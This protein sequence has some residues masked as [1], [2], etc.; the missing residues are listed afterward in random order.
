MR[1]C[2]R[3]SQF[4]LS[5]LWAA[6]C[7]LSLTAAFNSSLRAEPPSSSVV[8]LNGDQWLL[9]TDPKN[10]GREEKWFESPRPEAK[11]TKVPWIIQDAFPGYSGV[12][13]YWREFVAP[14]HPHPDG[15]YLLRFWAVDY[16]ADVWVNG[17]HVGTHEGAEIPFVLDI[18]E[19]VKPA[20]TNRLAVRV[21][22]VNQQRT[23]GLVMG[24]VPHRLKNL[25]VEQGLTTGG[26]FNHG[27]IE[28]S[29]ELLVTAPVRV[30]DLYVISDWQTGEIRVQA[31][32]QNSAA[33]PV[34]ARVQF[35]VAPAAAGETLD[36]TTVE[37]DLPVGETPVTGRLNVS[38]HRLWQLNDPYLYRI[39]ARATG[40]G[41]RAIDE[42]STRC[43]FRDF[44]FQNGYFRLNG[45]RIYLRCSHIG[46]D[47]PI[48]LQ[49]PHDPDVLRRTLLNV[50]VMGFNAVRFF[51]AVPQRFQLDLCDEIGLLA[52]E[53]SYAGWGLGDSPK[54]AERFDR[55]VAGMI[56][57]DRNHPSVVMWGL[58]N[59][60]PDGPVFRHA[61][62]MLPL[63]RSLDATRMVVLNSGRWDRTG[64]E[65]PAGLEVWQGSTTDP[66]VSRNPTERPIRTAGI[67]WL[68]GATVFHPGP[69]G[70]RCV[71]RWTTPADGEY[72][73]LA[74][75]RSAAARATT[76]VHVRR[77]ATRLFDG[78][79]NLHD[80]KTDPE[81]S[82]KLTLK[83]GETLDFL[84]GDGG[85]GY[86]ADSTEISVSITAA[87]GKIYDLSK[88]F[89]AARN[90]NGAWSYGH[91]PGSAEDPAAFVV[92]PKGLTFQRRPAV[93]SISNP[94]S[95]DWEDVLADV[96]PY[97]RSPATAGVIQT[98]R[99]LHGDG[100]PVFMSEYGIGSAVDLVRVTRHYERLASTHSMDAQV[101]RMRLEAFL[102]DWAR[103]G[104]GEC[105]ASPED[106]F[107]QCLAKMAGERLLGLNALRTNP[108]I[109]GHSMSSTVDQGI[110]GEGVFTTFRELKP[111]TVDALF[112]G[113][114]AL[115]LCLFVEP[116]HVYRGDKVRIEA[117]LANEDALPP[118]EYPV[119]LQVVGTAGR[120]VWERS[121]TLKI[122]ERG[123]N[124][125]PPL[126]MPFFGEEVTVDGAAGEYR[127]L[128]AFER[129]A[130]A[131][132]GEQRFHVTDR[133]DMPAVAVE[134]T[135]WGND[136]GLEQ[137]LTAHGIRVRRFTAEQTQREMIVASGPAPAEPRAFAVLAEHMARGSTVLFLTPETLRRGDH[138][139]GWIPLANKGTLQS[140]PHWL[141]VTD[142]WAKAHPFFE[143]LPCGGLLDY[144]FYREIIPDVAWTGQEPAGQCVA[145]AINAA[146][147]YSSGTLLSVHPFGAGR[148]VLNS[149]LIRPKLGADPVAERLLRNLLRHAA[150]EVGQPP[151]PLPADFEQQLKTLGY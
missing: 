90:P 130:A 142:E 53:E 86:G 131:A 105:F 6:V 36:A 149:F 58:L 1:S 2:T 28:G 14:A 110:S 80:Q 116:V 25:T 114:A 136:P 88:D 34:R 91:V 133:A 41:S 55:T 122:P 121:I 127:F 44:R 71:I 30:S 129:G 95:A 56:R 119:R 124:P 125:E 151:A 31:T 27:G 19:A 59:E 62:G 79:V 138:A 22:N 115:R 38:G 87:D 26:E 21:L 93:G 63:I 72:Q 75:F 50:K 17:R 132:G 81:Y 82:A 83:R 111:G 135:L 76:D 37:Q 137:W 102:R 98:L 35:L 51:C 103:L 146:W 7:I 45:K 16:L 29:V 109:V 118:G 8:S 141:Y 77:G 9:A 112:D 134:V 66:N 144:T 52:Y 65:Q 23:D 139:A 11:P 100:Q 46:N 97:Q 106:Y 94:G 85:N 48:G 70:E 113:W 84:V 147:G 92:Y 99:T 60:T 20:D 39:T 57:R 49:L 42:Q 104:M 40:E 54:L 67:T 140:M 3:H 73:V 69:D 74:R 32:V 24:E 108:A 145:G 68:P 143:G 4:G 5:C 96:H 15:R 150:R 12:A 33:V 123:D 148:F 89:S 120:R 78:F 18:T 128:A 101:Y 117:V 47:C 107:R 13:W 126:A 43:G 10:V 64:S 61:V